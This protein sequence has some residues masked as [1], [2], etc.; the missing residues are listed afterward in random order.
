MEEEELVLVP[1]LE[2][3]Y[4][5]TRSGRLYSLPKNTRKGIRE[6]AFCKSNYVLA[7]VSVGGKKTTVSQHRL[8][9]MMFI[10]N[11]HNKEEVN[12][13]NGNKHDNR[14][15]NLEWCTQSENT[16]HALKALKRQYGAVGEKHGVAKL[17]NSDVLKIKELLSKKVFHKE[18]AKMFGVC[19]DTIALISNGTHWKHIDYLHSV[20]ARLNTL[21]ETK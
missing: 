2:N 17:T 19:R 3:R 21:E 20:E 12:H 16:Q 15:E 11:P 1:S 5:I 6:I 8:L 13:I 9:A 14:I 10:P 4:A 7:G 18:I